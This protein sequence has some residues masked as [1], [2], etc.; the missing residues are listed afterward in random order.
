MLDKKQR[1]FIKKKVKSLG[2]KKKVLSF[3]KREDL[4]TKF[5]HK[6]AK[7]I[8][9]KKRRKKGEKGNFNTDKD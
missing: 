9:K 5:A 4:V 3:Y 2:S 8:Y 1:I 7:K 6:M